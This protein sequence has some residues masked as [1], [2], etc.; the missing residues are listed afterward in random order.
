MKYLMKL[1]MIPLVMIA[2]FACGGGEE[3]MVAEVINFKNSKEK[4]SFA[5]GVESAIGLFKEDAKFEDLDKAMLVE[6]FNSN[7]SD[8]PVTDCEETLRKFLGEQG[9]DFDTTYLKEGSRCIGRMSGYY[10]HMQMQQM[11]MM[12]EI[13]IEM[14]KK[15]F[16]QG[17]YEQDTV[18]MSADERTKV[19]KEFGE[20]IQNKFMAEIAEKDQIFWKDVLSRKGVTQV[21]QTGVYIET[22]K[23]GSGAQPEMTSDVEAHYILTNALGDTLQSSYAAGQPIQI[24]L[25]GVVQGWRDG[26]PA[27]KKGGKY[28]LFI[29]Y[30]KAYKG[31]DPQAPQGALCFFVE[32]INCGPAGSIVKPQ[33]QQMGGY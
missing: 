18:N 31:G 22:I 30:E 33:P 19:L 29:P 10:F 13:D 2:L 20:K 6:G 14:V 3:E 32:L 16:F 9:Q 26:F 28:R 12:S 25:S 15:G 1:G 21:G 8:A 5:I 24:N 4:V 27:M 17:V 11:G 23:A 7:I